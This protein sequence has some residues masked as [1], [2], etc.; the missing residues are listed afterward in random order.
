MA[1]FRKK[2][3]S[4]KY[5]APKRSHRKSGSSM[6]G[7]M[8][9]AAAAAYGAGRSYIA[10]W[11]APITSKVP[12]GNLAD[13]AVMLGVCWA[14]KKYVPVGIVKQAASAGMLIEAAMIG[15]ELAQNGM[16]AQGSSTSW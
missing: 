14:A 4:R 12:L 9:L 16:S 10:N 2:S 11:V 15:S 13:N 7:I 1:R 8:P 3:R 6:G 5:F